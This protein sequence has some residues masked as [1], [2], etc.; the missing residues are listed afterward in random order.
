MSHLEYLSTNAEAG[1][2]FNQAM[3][4]MTT[5][6][7]QQVV[8]AYD[9]SGVRTLV[10]VG[11]GNGVLLASILK[12]N[13]GMVGTLF[14]QPHALAG[15]ELVLT[16]EGVLQRVTLVAGDAL[17]AALPEADAYILKSVIHT[18]DDVYAARLLANLRRT[19]PVGG[20]LLLIERVIP[21]PNTPS[22]SKFVNVVMLAMTGGRERTE[23][24]YAALLAATDFAFARTL[25]LPSGFCI[26]EAVSV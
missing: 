11:G 9:F 18:L 12:H 25:S 15:A 21:G 20:K 10:D 24:E 2:I 4:Q 13:S 26:V 22:W 7:A 8:T 19:L 14:E 6:V 1:A 5:L 23:A 3:T 17:E 16:R